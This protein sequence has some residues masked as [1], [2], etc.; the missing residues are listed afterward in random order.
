MLLSI[1]ARVK[2]GM[3]SIEEMLNDFFVRSV[4][5]KD[6]NSQPKTLYTITISK[7]KNND[8]CQSF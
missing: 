6:L 7:I 4:L 5:Q 3:S 2:A 1:V 8:R